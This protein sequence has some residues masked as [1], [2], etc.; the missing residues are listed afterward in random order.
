ML[1]RKRGFAPR[2]E[3]GR[4]RPRREDQVSAIGNIATGLDQAE[5]FLGLPEILRTASIRLI[6]SKAMDE[7]IR[8]ESNSRSPLSRRFVIESEGNTHFP[9]R[10]VRQTLIP[11]HGI[12]ESLGYEGVVVRH[13]LASFPE[14]A[15][16]AGTE[17]YTGVI[18][19]TVGL[20]GGC[21]TNI[22]ISPKGLYEVDDVSGLDIK[23]GELK[24]EPKD[25]SRIA[26]GISASEL[27]IIF[28]NFEPDLQDNRPPQ[29]PRSF[30]RRIA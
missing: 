1:R 17:L 25:V 3:I 5:A 16:E 24:H 15:N 10:H 22:L 6:E 7:R 27:S 26:S 18:L 9:F 13:G 23:D 2:L 4:S 30:I 8:G 19:V 14:S 11:R 28:N 20:V 29:D 21:S 12:A